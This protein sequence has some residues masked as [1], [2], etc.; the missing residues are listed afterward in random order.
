MLRVKK[1]ITPIENYWDICPKGL[2][3]VESKSLSLNWTSIISVFNHVLR[4]FSIYM[5]KGTIYFNYCRSR[6]IAEE[7]V[8]TEG[9]IFTCMD[10]YNIDLHFKS[11]H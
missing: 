9:A 2:S 7:K 10:V 8:L 6:Q 11:D 3:S 5:I 1:D 4:H